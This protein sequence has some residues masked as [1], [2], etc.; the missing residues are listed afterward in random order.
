MRIKSGYVI[1]KVGEK[2]VIVAL[3]KISESV[4]RIM[5]VNETGSFIWNGLK[6]ELSQEQIISGLVEQYEVADEE[7]REDVA[8][9]ITL[10][11]EAELIEE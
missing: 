10:L 1:R 5:K 8:T 7:A 6:E 2:Y 11:R 4:S 9:F 3:G